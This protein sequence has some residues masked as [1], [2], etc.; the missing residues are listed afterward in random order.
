MADANKI[1]VQ[2][3]ARGGAELQRVIRTLWAETE[4]LNF[5]GFLSESRIPR[6]AFT[7]WPSDDAAHNQERSPGGSSIQKGR[8]TSDTGQP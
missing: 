3:E 6:R 5:H 2:F 7:L 1:S 8:C 4:R